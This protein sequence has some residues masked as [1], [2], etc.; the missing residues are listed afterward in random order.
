MNRWLSLILALFLL[1]TL[2]GSGLAAAP[3]PKLADELHVFNW[4]EY[5]DPEIYQDFEDEFGV[6]CY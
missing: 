3:D 4:S 6:K 5:I 1:V 2:A